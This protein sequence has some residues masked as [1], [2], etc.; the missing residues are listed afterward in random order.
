M[1]EPVIT[2]A[3]S[4]P[5]PTVG[6]RGSVVLGASGS[7]PRPRTAVW[8]RLAAIVFARLAVSGGTRVVYPFLP[9]IAHGL[10]LSFSTV[11]LLVAS[12]SLAGL[13][14]PAV[15]GIARRGNHRHPMLGALGLVAGGC[16]VI[17][18]PW[19]GPIEVRVAVVG[20][21][22][23]A[24]GLARPLFDL[25]MQAWI[26]T[27]VPEGKRGRAYGLGEAGW[28]L[29]L[30]ATV[31][32]AGVLVGHA[33]WRSPFLLVAGLAVCGVAVLAMA[34]P[35][36]PADVATSRPAASPP[37][38]ARSRPKT[39]VARPPAT[40]RAL[41]RRGPTGAAICLAAGLAVA[42]GESFFVVYGEWLARDFD[43]SVA[44]IGASVLLIV[45]AELL[46][47]GLVAAAADRVG[48]RRMAFVG[49]GLAAT[50]HLSL[51]AVGPHV[52]AAFAVTT[53]VFVAFEMTVVSLITLASLAEGSDRARTSLFGRLMAAVAAGNVL[54]AIAA[55][56]LFERG[57]ITLTG[58]MA[59][60]AT[61][62]AMAALR[63]GYASTQPRPAR[64]RPSTIPR[65]VQRAPGRARRRKRC[66]RAGPTRRSVVPRSAS[67]CRQGE[68]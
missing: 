51:A 36:T 16:V 55:P 52:A 34:L 25:P 29:S 66:H 50:A 54:G 53:V 39:A 14:G 62:A 21:G 26:S 58:A 31:P 10:G 27:H 38:V 42:A 17:V 5:G 44:R 35:A 13:L 22:F 2:A 49:M 64:L 67:P 4:S 28:A 56:T 46:G 3:P 47:E 18:T 43:L 8:Q 9:V 7:T 68:G 24:T 61:I 33:G 57:G 20:L 48:L 32:A 45:A 23:A 41:V 65:T 1:G 63:A 37:A 6:A 19:P 60:T 30:A 12:R 59:A 15:A 11:A 40:G